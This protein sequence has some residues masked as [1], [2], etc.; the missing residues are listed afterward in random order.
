MCSEN[1]KEGIQSI[2]FYF[3]SEFKKH[4]GF[5]YKISWGKDQKLVE[6]LL[7][8]YGEE[9]LKLAI[10][11]L[12]RKYQAGDEFLQKAGLS[13]GVFYSQINKLLTSTRKE[14]NSHHHNS[15]TESQKDTAEFLARI[16]ATRTIQLAPI[17]SSGKND[18][19]ELGSPTS[20]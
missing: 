10:T 6:E 1:T 5:P 15:T 11:E 13:I 20:G 17:T 7:R 14:V 16:R 9:K 19:A 2:I 4:I 8:L 12:F 18:A 3:D